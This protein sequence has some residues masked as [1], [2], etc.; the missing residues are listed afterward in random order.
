SSTFDTHSASCRHPTLLFHLSIIRRPPSF[1]LFPYTTLFRSNFHADPESI[2]EAKMKRQTVSVSQIN[3]FG[4]FDLGSGRTL[5]ACLI[6]ASRAREP[7]NHPSGCA[8]VDRA[9]DG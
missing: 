5:A 8:S 4:E 1:T 2:F 6:H 9:A 3:F 7:D